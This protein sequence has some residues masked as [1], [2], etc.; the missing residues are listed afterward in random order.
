VVRLSWFEEPGGDGGTPSDER[1]A[2]DHGTEAIIG[3]E[4]Q[5]WDSRLA[6]IVM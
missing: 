4:P 5:S 6:I 2:T 1:R 3:K